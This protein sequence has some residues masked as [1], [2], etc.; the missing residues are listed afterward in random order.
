[1]NAYERFPEPRKVSV[2]ALVPNKQLIGKTF[3]KEAKV[4]QTALEALQVSTACRPAC[5]HTLPTGR[6]SASC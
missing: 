5:T 6:Q 1:M 4:V 3:K 2:T